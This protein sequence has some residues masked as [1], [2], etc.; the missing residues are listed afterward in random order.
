MDAQ[1][2]QR[3]AVNALLLTCG[4][5]ALPDSTYCDIQTTNPIG[6]TEII[7]RANVSH[8]VGTSVS[9]ICLCPTDYRRLV[10][11]TQTWLRPIKSYRNQKPH[12][13]K[14]LS[15]F[16]M[17][18]GLNPAVSAKRRCVFLALFQYLDY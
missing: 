8:F 1:P 11:I 4:S 16:R 5:V 6:F 17:I 7:R 13:D 10:L 14:S 3:K 12:S 15:T 18:Q 9:R 2:E